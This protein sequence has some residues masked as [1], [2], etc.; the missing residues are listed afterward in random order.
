MAMLRSRNSYLALAVAVTSLAVLSSCGPTFGYVSH[1]FSLGESA[2]L[3]DASFCRVKVETS[4]NDKI[5]VNKAISDAGLSDIKSLVNSLETI[6]DGEYHYVTLTGVARDDYFSRVMT[7]ND[8]LSYLLSIK[9]NGESFYIGYFPS[10]DIYTYFVFAPFE[11]HYYFRSDAN[12]T[13]LSA[14]KSVHTALNSKTYETASSQEI[15][16]TE[17]NIVEVLFPF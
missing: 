13:S 16:K 10:N 5:Y 6:I 3:T 2:T 15:T 1:S 9:N 12:E 17:E 4:A 14:I 7:P 11:N 8:D